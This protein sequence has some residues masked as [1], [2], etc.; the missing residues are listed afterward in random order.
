ME[1]FTRRLTILSISLL[2]TLTVVAPEPAFASLELCNRTKAGS[3][4]SVALAHYNFGTLHRRFRKDGSTGLTIT[5]NPRWTIRGWWEIP[6]NECIV[7]AT[8]RDLSLNYYYYY[9]R[10]Q[11]GSYNTSGNYPLCGRKYGQFHVEY[12]INSDNQPVQIL[13]LSPSDL[14]SVSLTPENNLQTACADLGY[15]L[16]PFNQIDVGDSETYTLNVLD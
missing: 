15:E 11:D 4:L 14:D 3:S 6:H 5:V 1:R 9:A 8:D 12:Q 16:L 7:A 10:S 2:T 13:A